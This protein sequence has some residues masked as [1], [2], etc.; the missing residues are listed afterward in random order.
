MVAMA[1]SRSRL[2]GED[3]G[4]HEGLL[5]W[6][7]KVLVL[8]GCRRCCVKLA[9]VEVRISAVVLKRWRCCCSDGG[10]SNVKDLQCRCA[11]ILA[12]VNGGT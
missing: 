8:R 9:V 3:D 10:G 11:L 5:P 12:H 2:R 1:R 7:S 4:C 6:S